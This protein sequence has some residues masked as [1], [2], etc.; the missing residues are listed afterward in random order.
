MQETMTSTQ[1]NKLFT[2]K[3]QP[4]QKVTPAPAKPKK[5]PDLVE[6]ID[7]LLEHLGWECDL[8]RAFCLDERNPE[9]TAETTAKNNA[10]AIFRISSER[11]IPR[12]AH[13]GWI[14]DVEKMSDE[15]VIERV[16]QIERRARDD[17]QSTHAD[18]EA[19]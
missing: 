8:Y 6:R 12:I 17:Y 19:V 3:K 9:N 18:R 2:Q 1:Y 13:L 7:A 16:E 10:V 4:K 11:Y 15:Q 14:W 5:A